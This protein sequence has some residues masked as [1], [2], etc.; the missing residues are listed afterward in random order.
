MIRHPEQIF[1]LLLMQFSIAVFIGE[2][3]AV[4]I[5]DRESELTEQRQRHFAVID[6]LV[7]L[8]VP[9]LALQYLQRQQP[10]LTEQAPFNWL[11]WE[12]KHIQLLDY[13]KHWDTIDQRITDYAPKL[14]LANVATADR[15][16]FQTQQIHALLQAGK[17]HDALTK[18]R[19]LLWNANHFVKSEQLA[20]WRRLIIQIYLEQERVTD[21]QVAMRRYQQDYGELQNEDGLSW[22]Q[23]QADLYLQLQQYA[24]AIP[25]LRQVDIPLARVQLWLAMLL[26]GQ[27]TEIEVLEKSSMLMAT[28]KDEDRGRHLYLYLEALMYVRLAQLDKAIPLLET[29]IA[30]VES[31]PA[32]LSRLAQLKLDG[33]ALWQYYEKYGLSFA[34]R[35]G[36]LQGDDAAWYALAS[37]LYEDD[38]ITAR[39]LFAVLALYATEQHQRQMAMQQLVSLLGENTHAL[40]LV[41]QLFTE[42]ARVSDITQVP[43]EVRYALIDY[44]LSRGQIPDAAEIMA[45]L[46][47]PPRDQPQFDWNL[48]RARVLILSG[49]FEPG[50]SILNNLL[51][52]PLEAKQADRFL[53][54]VFDL[55]AVEQHAIALQ[56]FMRMQQQ[57][58]DPR[59]QRELVFWQAE[60]YAG[61]Q[62]Y[63]RAAYLFLKSARSTDKGFDPWYHTA[64]FRAAESLADA[65]LF[66]DARRQ[67]L[68]LLDI[69]GNAARKAVIR[70]RLQSIQLKSQ[71]NE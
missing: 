30:S 10:E 5:A 28:L 61:M 17:S 43:A 32:S 21:A 48:R 38:P 63:D 29:L 14:K 52:Q 19:A 69:T 46:K 44:H 49:A 36:L 59:I 33:D 58:D 3:V 64:T 27:M 20:N 47:Q 15:N 35:R 26:Q 23:L 54:V 12:Q 53:Q 67:F 65:G 42:S 40:R 62:Q 8:Q 6:E 37:N 41:N 70:Q 9:G 68:H 66:L 25:L 31:V 51:E 56:L 60:S 55:Q 13:L 16:W 45:G 50:G 18:V 22:I 39:S 1:L 34:N 57:V 71:H 11:F 2:A 7:S 24:E 4:E